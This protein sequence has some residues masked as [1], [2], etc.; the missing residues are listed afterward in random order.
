MALIAKIWNGVRQLIGLILPFFARARDLRN[1]G[2]QFRKVLH[3]LLV[4]AIL[5]VLGVIHY[6]LDLGRLLPTAGLLLRNLWLPFLFLLVYVLSWLGWWLWKLL[7]PEA[8]AS[9]STKPEST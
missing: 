5:V 3:V 9:P 1:V 2:P 4:V 6:L 8:E 7:Q